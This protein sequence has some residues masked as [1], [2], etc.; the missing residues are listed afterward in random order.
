MKK[1]INKN[2]II[3]AKWMSRDILMVDKKIKFNGDW[4]RFE[5]NEEIWK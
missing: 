4:K 2:E 5:C 1:K 3:E